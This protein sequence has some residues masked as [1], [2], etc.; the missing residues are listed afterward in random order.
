LRRQKFDFALLGFPTDLAGFE[1]ETV[2]TV[3]LVVTL[4]SRHVGARRKLVSL[5]DL[6]GLPLFWFKRPFNPPYFDHCA[7]VFDTL[8]PALTF[9][10]VPPGQLSTLDRIRQGEGFA[11]LTPMRNRA[12]AQSD[13]RRW[14]AR[15][16]RTGVRN[17]EHGSAIILIPLWNLSES[18]FRPDCFTRIPRAS[19]CRRNRSSTWSSPWPTG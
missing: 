15:C 13:L 12:R 7:R 19:S 6:A 14:R 5:Q 8:R 2:H 4:P 1:K 10:N 11:L 18:A 9:I 3:A 17:L 16:F